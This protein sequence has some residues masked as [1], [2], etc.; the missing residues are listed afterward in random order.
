[1]TIK[2]C[3]CGRPKGNRP[4]CERCEELDGRRPA[5]RDAI[6]ALRAMGGIANSKALESYMK[7]GRRHLLRL[8]ARLMR[9]GRIRRVVTGM[10]GV[11]GTEPQFILVERL[12]D[13]PDARPP[14]SPSSAGQLVLPGRGFARPCRHDQTRPVQTLAGRTIGAVCARCGIVVVKPIR[15]EAEASQAVMS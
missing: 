6:A 14:P 5:D 11:I 2:R 10:V 15:V 7:V 9:E 8:M 12:R 4:T 13:R 1:M 3:E